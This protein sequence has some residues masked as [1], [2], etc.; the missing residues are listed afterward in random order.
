MVSVLTM[1]TFLQLRPI[2]QSW[3]NYRKGT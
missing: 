3:R 1:R 2:A